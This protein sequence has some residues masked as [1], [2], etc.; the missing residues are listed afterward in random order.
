[1]WPEQEGIDLTEDGAAL[2]AR[3]ADGG[4]RDALSLLDQ[5]AVGGGTGGPSPGCWTPWG[6]RA[7]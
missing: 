5:C 1:M 3:L 7:T 2:L 4:M 6:W